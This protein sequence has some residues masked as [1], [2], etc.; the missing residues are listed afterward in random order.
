M[1]NEFWGGFALNDVTR[2]GEFWFDNIVHVVGVLVVGS[3]VA[4][5]G[6]HEVLANGQTYGWSVAAP[7]ILIAQFVFSSRWKT[8]FFVESPVGN[9]GTIWI[10][11]VFQLANGCF[12]CRLLINIISFGVLTSFPITNRNTKKKLQNN[13]DQCFGANLRH[14]FFARFCRK[15]RSFLCILAMKHK[16][17]KNAYFNQ[18]LES[19]APKCWLKYTTLDVASLVTLFHVVLF[20][21]IYSQLSILHV[22]LSVRL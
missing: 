14:L 11:C 18:R 5:V 2:W 8:P 20:A 4:L 15:N 19:G 21:L 12:A 22:W 16:N 7:C 9:T 1:W 17:V 3:V 6:G 10:C 13:F